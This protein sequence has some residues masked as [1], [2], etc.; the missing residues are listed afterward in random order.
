[1]RAQDQGCVV[2]GV[3]ALAAAAFALAGGLAP[4]LAAILVAGL[5]L[6]LARFAALRAP[7]PLSPTLGW[8]LLLPRGRHGRR[9]V[10]SFLRPR[11]GQ[12]VLEIGSGPGAHTLRIARELAPGGSIVAVDLQRAMLRSLARRVR[13]A[14]L[15]NV[16]PVRADAR[17]IPCADGRFDAVLMIAAL[18]EIPRHRSAVGEAAR[19]L[20]PGGRLIVGETLLDPDHVP[21]RRLL[22]A[23]HGLHLR[24][25]EVRGSRFSYLTAFERTRDV[26]SR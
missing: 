2:A 22:D 12:R 6:A 14:G 18:G 16:R 17:H 13:S 21:L 19:V 8:A 26:R 5:G 25:E 24:L 3:G 23:T 20:R 10:I 4:A 9:A 11:P 7:A 1:M 15:P